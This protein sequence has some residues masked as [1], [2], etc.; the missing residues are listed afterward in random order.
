MDLS[1][2]FKNLLTKQSPPPSPNTV[3]NY[4]ADIRY[5][6]N[7][8]ARTYSRDFT[9][10]ELNTDVITSFSQDTAVSP[11]T[12]E[13]HIASLKKLISLLN[14]S[15]EAIES[16]FHITAKPAETDKWKLRQFKHYLYKQKASAVTVK[17][18]LSDLS[19][20]TKWI[21]AQYASQE[22]I[23]ISEDLISE[24]T[25]ALIYVLQFSPKSVNRKMSS[26]RKYMEFSSA[27]TPVTQTY[28]T[29][30]PLPQH[31]QQPSGKELAALDA[32]RVRENT[33]SRIAPLRLI[34][35][36]G[37]VYGKAEEK[38]AYHVSR[39]VP[40]RKNSSPKNH[41]GIIHRI[42]NNRPEWYITYHS[43]SFAKY[44]HISALAVFCV[45]LLLFGYTRY[46][47]VPLESDVLGSM[48]QDR[49]VLVYSGKLSNTDS[50]PITRP[51][52]LTFSIYPDQTANNTVLWKETH[53]INPNQN[54][55]FS[56]QLGRKEVLSNSFFTDNQNLYLGMT[57]EPGPELLPR[58]RLAN[59]GYA[60]DSSS[61]QGM[62][63][64]TQNPAETAN[65]ILAFDS[66]GNLVIGGSANPI[67]QA[68][69]GNLTISGTTTILT[70]EIGSNGSI[71]LNP[72]GLGVIDI[73]RPIMNT[74]ED[75]SSSG[76]VDF[77][78]EVVIATDSATSL[79]TVHNTG[80]FGDIMTLMSENIQ[81]M[82]VNAAGNIG[83][84][85]ATPSHL[86]HIAGDSNPTLSIENSMSGTRLDV[87][88]QE[89]LATI[90]THSNTGLGFKTNDLVRMHI[91]P[92]GNVGIGTSTPTALLD[93]NGSASISGTLTLTG[94]AQNIQ[95]ANNNNLIVG[96]NTT[97]N[98][99][100]QPLNGDGFV[101]VST[102]SPEFK[103]DIHDNQKSRAAMQI[104]NTSDSKDADG[105]TIRLGSKEASLSATNTFIDFQ[106]DR[107]G[108]VGSITGNGTG[109]SFNTT[110]ADFA[111]YLKK[112]VSED[113]PY[114]TIT[115][116]TTSG[117]VSACS[118]ENY[119]I[120]GVTSQN[121]AFLGGKDHGAASVAVGL[122]GQIE[123]YVSTENGPIKAGD[124][125]TFSTRPG[126]GVKATSAGM[127][128]G[129]ALH[130]YT[131][132]KIGKVLVLVQPSWHEP[133]AT[134]TIS[135]ELVTTQLTEISLDNS[136]YEQVAK[137]LAQST[138]Y[139]KRENKTVS[140]IVSFASATIGRIKTSLLEA[141]DIIVSGTIAARHIVVEQL[142]V[143]SDNIRVNGLSL[144]DYIASVL[145]NDDFTPDVVTAGDIKSNF[146]SPLAEDSNIAVSLTDSTFEI[147]DSN[148]ATGSAVAT[149]DTEGNAIF[150]GDIQASDASFSGSISVQDASIAG[151]LSVDT[152]RAGTIEGLDDKIASVFQEQRAKESANIE[153][154]GEQQPA[155]DISPSF[156]TGNWNVETSNFMDIG[157]VSA[158]FAL[159]HEN[160]LS[161]GTTTLR[162]ATVMDSF[163]IGTNF[164]FGPGSLDVLGN[165]LQIQ[166]LRQG[167]VSFLAGLV[168]ID[169]N[170]NLAVAG[171]ASFA[172]NVTIKGGLFANIISPLPDMDLDIFLPNKN[173][174]ESAQFRIVNGSKT[175]VLAINGNG[176]VHS[177]GSANFVG[178]LVASGSAFLSKLNIFSQEAQ[179]LSENELVASSSAGTA[180]LTAYKRE[181][182][183]HSPYVTGDSLIYITPSTDTGNQVLY[184]LRQSEEGSFTVGVNQAAQQDIEF[185]WFVVN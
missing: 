171:D 38:A 71:V 65:S 77:A 68:T 183:I 57:I 179:A 15:G 83:I 11:R 128:V 169:S 25:N 153:E 141:Q 99:I 55:S 42:R 41:Q 149:I 142:D 145:P 107:L 129:R 160:L 172:Q 48:L 96:G 112:D 80:A 120:V 122:V 74:S 45:G 102:N 157:T 4:V 21:D 127:I 56:V 47:H 103:L 61:L 13:R 135:G 17:N 51:T 84:G 176:D 173:S 28:N 143:T 177:S 101:G 39:L 180:T 114:G 33:Y 88:A 76:S 181:V 163:S 67:F 144:A 20:F 109:I 166:P 73:Q 64:I 1:L 22:N 151:T 52:K 164:I 49:R 7:W 78:D 134:L 66:S 50:T 89:S 152:V 174:T 86:V 182:T 132:N 18:Y 178:D 105:L 147:L 60:Q 63:P 140:E 35:K 133:R 126:V 123:T 121:P 54:G 125:I 156:T 70:T 95:S 82:V 162:E 146:I 118:H 31:I 119:Q 40:D 79:F 110:N 26:I 36:V 5:F 75:A 130:S 98:I 6:S 184:L 161:L 30:A 23:K 91:S 170:G 24:Y 37:G 136:S 175:P 159:F 111:E 106:S 138:A 167:G 62:A 148:E 97:G 72:D 85:I 81:R 185:N 165:D 113:I 131:E 59:V 104:Y 16:P 115:C 100:L 44:I 19:H 168:S 14:A 155:T 46:M 108:S 58:Q 137:A 12:K 150:A 90:G 3:K 116:L 154:S 69:G 10:S 139:V 8:Y 117:T 158:Q 124:P 27:H 53:E 93:I 92:T 94:G 32:F 43:H 9:L 87:S 29:I 34:Q 2:L